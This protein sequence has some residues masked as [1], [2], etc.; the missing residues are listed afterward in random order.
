[1][2]CRHLSGLPRIVT[3][4]SRG[5]GF[6]PDDECVVALLAFLTAVAGRGATVSHGIER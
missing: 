3:I 2:Q 1:M 5:L 4:C 6:F